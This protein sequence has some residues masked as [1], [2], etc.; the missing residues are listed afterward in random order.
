M[1]QTK[2]EI[3]IT[4]SRASYSTIISNKNDVLKKQI[5]KRNRPTLQH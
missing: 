1:F 5:K 3:I 2:P 4:L